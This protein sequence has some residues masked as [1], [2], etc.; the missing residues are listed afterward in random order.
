V[1]EKWLVAVR[2]HPARPPAHQR[3][4]LVCLALRM[5]WRTGRG[6]AAL[7]QIAADSDASEPTVRRATSWARRAELLLQT[8]RGHRLGNGQVA[9]SEWRLTQP[10]TGELLSSQPLNGQISTAQQ[11]DLNRSAETPH[12][13]SSSSE[14]SSSLSLEDMLA[15]AVPGATEREI[16]EAVTDIQTRHARGEIRSIRAYLKKIIAEG[17]AADLIE[18]ARGV[19]ARD[20]APGRPPAITELCARCGG[21]GHQRQDCTL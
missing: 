15:G 13:E 12:Q 21:R 2:D 11:A 18:Q 7:R 6:F 8:R 9:A 10:L 3:Y 5:D 4:V 16:E 20:S 14:S 17:D 19:I 1:I